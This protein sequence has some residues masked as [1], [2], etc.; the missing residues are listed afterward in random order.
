[1]RYDGVTDR[2]IVGHV[3]AILR[4]GQSAAAVW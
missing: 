1:M 3:E 4:R 2:A